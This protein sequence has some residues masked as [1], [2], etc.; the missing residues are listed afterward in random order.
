MAVR[1]IFL[2]KLA[3][4]AGVERGID[5]PIE[6]SDLR[7]ILGPELAAEVQRPSVKLALN[8]ALL[9]DKTLLCAKDGDEIAFLP[10]VSGG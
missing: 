4:M 7:S 6:W 5:G 2:G 1:L 9:S 3:D 10:P 8:G